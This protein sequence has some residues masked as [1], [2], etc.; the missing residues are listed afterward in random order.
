MSPAAPSSNGAVE[1]PLLGRHLR[2]AQD[3]FEV[4]LGPSRPAHL[5]DHRLG[6]LVVFPAAGYVEMARAAGAALF[7]AHGS[8]SVNDLRFDR[9]LVLDSDAPRIVQTIVERIDERFLKFRIFSLN[10]ESGSHAPFTASWTLHASGSLSVLDA[11]PDAAPADSGDRDGA[12]DEATLREPFVDRSV[13]EN[14]ARFAAGGIDYGP[15]HR[16]VRSLRLGPDRARGVLRV[17]DALAAEAS[18]YAIHPVLLDGALQLLG[19]AM[20]ESDGSPADGKIRIPTSIGRVCVHPRV[21]VS[22]HADARVTARAEDGRCTGDLRLVDDAGRLLLTIEG[23]ESRRITLDPLLARSTNRWKDWLYETGWV[24]RATLAVPSRRPAAR[25]RSPA[26]IDVSVAS[27][28]PSMERGL[29]LYDEV[30]DELD[31][32]AVMYVRAALRTLDRH[33]EAASTSR[34]AVA[35]QHQRLLVHLRGMADGSDRADGDNLRARLDRLTARAPEYRAEIDL[36]AA[37]GENLAAVLRGTIDPLHLI[38]PDGAFEG[39][40]ALYRDSPM[41]RPANLLVA[42]AAAEAVA[43]RPDTRPLRVLEIGGG[44]GGTTFHLLPRLPAERTEY[45]FTDVSAAFLAPAEERFSGYTGFRTAMLDIERDPLAQGFAPGAFDLVLASNVLHATAS[46]AVTLKHARSLV[47]PGGLLFV[48]E[49]TEPRRWVDLVF[50]LTDG[51]WK[52]ADTNVRPSHPLLPSRAWTTLLREAGF[53]HVAPLPASDGDDRSWWR[54]QTVLAARAPLAVLENRS[55]SIHVAPASSNELSS[56]WLILADRAGIGYE[57]AERF[58]RRGESCRLAY[59]LDGGPSDAAIDPLDADRIRTLVRGFIDDAVGERSREIVYLWGV[60]LPDAATMTSDALDAFERRALGG[61]LH[62]VQAAAAAAA[63]LRLHIVTR[64]ATSVDGAPLPGFPAASLSG[65]ARV[66]TL[67]HP[68]L[69][70]ALIDLDPAAAAM[71]VDARTVIDLDDELH[72]P[73]EPDDVAFRS[74]ERWVQRLVRRRDSLERSTPLQLRPDA[75][76]IVTGGLTGL[77]RAT[78]RFLVEHGARWLV[79]AGRRAPAL[80]AAVEIDALR[81]RG[82]HVEVAQV[83]VTNREAVRSVLDGI[84][85]NGPPL[86]GVVH[87]AGL[88]EDGLLAQ[89][90]WSS[91]AKVLGTKIAGAFNLHAET[92]D[93]PIEHFLLYS[94]SVG[95]LGSAGQGNHAAANA[96]MDALARHRRATGRAALSIAWGA[97]S[98]IGS[99]A[100]QE[101]GERL[102]A[103]GIGRIDT[104]AGLEVLGHLMCDPPACRVVLPAD[105]A[106]YLAAFRP[107]SRQPLLSHL[108]RESGSRAPGAAR[109]TTGI[110]QRIDAALPRER[111]AVLADFIRTMVSKVLGNVS[112]TTTRSDQPFQELGL[113]SL[114][115]LEFRNALQDE[116]GITLPSTLALNFPTIDTLTGYLATRLLTETVS[117]QPESGA[118]HRPALPADSS[119]A[120]VAGNGLQ[121]VLADVLTLSEDEARHALRQGSVPR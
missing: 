4:D 71:P 85:R 39:A 89:Q 47:A 25:L 111:R 40:A 86:R 18:R 6:G 112:D 100:R 13:D 20:A 27:Q 81:N 33:D 68:E 114:M 83:D 93:D 53:D 77:G 15:A 64:G 117:A 41:A 38:F 17:P 78:A 96:F 36:V 102:L 16:V 10:D 49:G 115:A 45:V 119:V 97:W 42:A 22:A 79:L 9:A 12:I 37:C 106:T 61:A 43:A 35:P 92:L 84:R 3:I 72:R 94:S 103:R 121:G 63:P 80:D 107:G 118:D 48:V 75:A 8:I 69:R 91:F 56:A 73:G 52:F 1:H 46:L 110:L 59:A 66:L 65:F 88:L 34:Q 70:G 82:A 44:T 67:E 101:V 29:E 58:A 24:P 76:W 19:A 26:E 5:D 54:H 11:I 31:T 109:G 98:E 108:A 57:L 62:V 2:T 30:N 95:V 74:G 28:L 14:Y 90:P 116:F 120:A 99:A 105:W 32:V 55:P 104:R 7:S 60:D 21:G 113:D 51:W 87:S 23:L 50:G